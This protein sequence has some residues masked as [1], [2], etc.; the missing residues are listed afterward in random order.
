MKQH[1]K[2]QKKLQKFKETY[3]DAIADIRVNNREWTER[4][5]EKQ[6]NYYCRP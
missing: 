5:E 4:Y 2:E 1:V 6:K 3:D